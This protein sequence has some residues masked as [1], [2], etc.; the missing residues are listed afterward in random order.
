MI[1]R[2]YETKVHVAG[3]D[4]RMVHGYKRVHTDINAYTHFTRFI[5]KLL[6]EDNRRFPLPAGWLF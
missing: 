1:C 4:S 5:L 2:D 3:A 6:Y